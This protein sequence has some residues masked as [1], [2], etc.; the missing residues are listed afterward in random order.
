VKKGLFLINTGP[1]KGKTTAAIGTLIRGIGQGHRTAFI[2]FIKSTVTGE[3]RFLSEYAKTY[4]EKLF[5]AKM[6]L[7]FLKTGPT[8]KDLEKARQAMELAYQYRDGTDLLVLD[9]VNVAV[10]KGLIPLQ[11]AVDFAEGR[12]PRLNLIFTGRGCPQELINL[13]DTVTEMTEIKHAY[14]SGIPAR[15]GID[16]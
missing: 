12:P 9:E 10:N 1:G 14:R 15:K 2:Q 5:Y 3:S 8:E 7:G 4:P 6:G 11:D 13:A 16:F